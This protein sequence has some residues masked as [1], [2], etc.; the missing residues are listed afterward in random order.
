MDLA[1]DADYLFSLMDLFF[2]KGV[3]VFLTELLKSSLHEF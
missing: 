3:N 1:P 2:Q